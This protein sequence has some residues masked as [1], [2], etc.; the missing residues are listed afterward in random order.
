M[1]RTN[2]KNRERNTFILVGVLSLV[3]VGVL[4]RPTGGSAQNPGKV[5]EPQKDTAPAATAVQNQT[6]DA[7]AWE[8][9]RPLPATVPD[10]MH[11]VIPEPVVEKKV[12]KKLAEHDQ[13]TEEAELQPIKIT[14][15]VYTARKPSVI[16]NG[17][18][19]YPGDTVQGALILAIQRDGIE[20][21]RDG[22]IWKQSVHEK[23]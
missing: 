17:K 15:L 14:G 23:K 19:L 21:E 7:A 1:E 16:I 8:P 18:I 10:P 12:E 3:L 20:L 4:L 6:I 13:D 22:E 2:E 11:F 9:P 5:T